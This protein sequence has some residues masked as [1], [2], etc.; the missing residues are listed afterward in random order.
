MRTRRSANE[1]VAEVARRRLEQLSAELAAVRPDPEQATTAGPWSAPADG[2]TEDHAA[3]TGRGAGPEAGP[4]PGPMPARVQD[5]VAALGGMPTGRW[6]RRPGSPAGSRT[7]C[8]RP[9]R[10]G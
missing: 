7:G 6:G 2:R 3:G 4:R 9:C 1:E 8:P 10:A 5:G